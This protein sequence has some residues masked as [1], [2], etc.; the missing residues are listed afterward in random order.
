MGISFVIFYSLIH[1]GMTDIYRP[2][3]INNLADITFQNCEFDVGFKITDFNDQSKSLQ[4]KT[5]STVCDKYV[6]NYTI[7]NTSALNLALE[8]LYQ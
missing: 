4:F 3:F 2:D 5:S 8:K 7:D 6:K 1:L